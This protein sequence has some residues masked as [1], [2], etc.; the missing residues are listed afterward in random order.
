MNVTCLALEPGGHL[1]PEAEATAVA[2]WRAGAGP[3]WIHLGGGSPAAVTAWL[4]GLGLD[5]GLLDLLLADPGETRI[6]PLPEAVFVAYPVP[7]SVEG[8]PPDHFACLCL[9]RLVITMFDQA[10]SAPR[11]ATTSIQDLK[12]PEPTTAGVVCALALAQASRLRRQVVA[13]RGRGDALAGR[14]DSDPEA[15]P[16]EE[17]LALKRQVLAMGGLADEELAVLEIL[18]ASRREVLPLQRLADTFQIAIEITRATDRDTDR[19]EHRIGDL[20]RRHESIQ[21]D[22]TNRRLAQ[23]TVISAIFMPLT[24]IAGIYG[25]NFE[26]MP[27]LHFRWGYPA[28]LLGM[29][30]VAGGTLW[31][32]RSRWKAK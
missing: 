3:W 17:I 7:A 22:R 32:L 18:K 1:R 31:Y 29:A 13:L 21:Q 26:F 2:G 20:Q 6:I 16:L 15:V 10:P 14:M 28:A 24:L 12:I 19:L 11:L 5:Q 23:L 25:M 4:A 8:M 30:L 27:E 9:D